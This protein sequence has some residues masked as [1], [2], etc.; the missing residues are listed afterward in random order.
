MIHFHNSTYFRFVKYNLHVSCPEF[1][2]LLKSNPK[3]LEKIASEDKYG[4]KM[5]KKTDASGGASTSSSVV[6]LSELENN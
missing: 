6:D 2:Q 4:F 3:L 5:G 1:F